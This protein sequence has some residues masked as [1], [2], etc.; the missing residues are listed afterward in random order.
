MDLNATFNASAEVSAQP[1]LWGGIECTINRVGDVFFDQLIYAQHYKRKDDIANI[2]RLGIKK[3]RYPVLWE[4]HQ[5]QLG[6]EIDWTWIAGQLEQIKDAGIDAIAGLVH[7]GSGPAFTNMLDPQF[8]YLLAAYARNV[9]ERFPH[10]KYYTPVNEPLTTARFSGLYGIWYPHHTSDE[11]FCKMLIHEVKATVLAMQAIREVNPQAQLVETEDLGK[12]YSTPLLKYQ[13]DFENERRWLTYDLL[14]GKVNKSH[15][16]YRYLLATGVSESD[17]NFFLD[18]PCVPDVFGFNHYV[19]SERFLDERLHLYAPHTHGGNGRHQYADVE[20]VRVEVEEET[21]VKVLLQ[22]AWERYHQP[23]A[24]TEVHL[25]CHREEQLRWFQYVWNAAKELKQSGVQIEAVTAWAL[26]GSYG[27]NKLLTKP[28]GTYEPG[29]FDLRG[30]YMRP[31]ALAA[32]LRKLTQTPNVAHPTLVEKGWWQRETRF[33][34]STPVLHLHIDGFAKPNTAPI[35]IVGKTG[36]LGKA[37][38]HICRERSIPFVLVGRKDCDI[39]DV[40]MVNRAIDRFKP[41]AVINT[42]GFVQVDEA[43]QQQERCFRENCTGAVVL[44]DACRQK[45]IRY[46]TFSSDM[47]FDGAKAK[48]YKESDSVNPLNVYG[49]SKARCEEEVLLA[50]HESLVV[51][52]SAFFGPWDEYN[53]LHYV[54]ENLSVQ[55]GITV[56]NDVFISPTYVPDLVHMALDLLIDEEKGIR[57]LANKG[58]ISW[59]A[60]AQE[61]AKM[62]RLNNIYINAVPLAEMKLEAKRP[63]YSVLGTEKGMI[64]PTL[65]DALRRFAQE[66]KPKVSTQLII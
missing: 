1:E 59:A 20:V 41:W 12:I 53:F 65:D 9:A 24:I 29:V 54:I 61:T 16:L 55:K 33:F 22:E 49:Q 37:F 26:L 7:H 32:Y 57:H 38:A 44:A 3:L 10:I 31:T 23:I 28:K 52:T 15:A 50:N 30:G 39:A 18:N 56:A 27:W 51:R 62:F 2:A 43:E 6:T 13:A 60:L 34:N 63:Q 14:C 35:M 4:K 36:T 47:V 66:R 42:A 19:T 64:M 58:S 46:L 8:P 5:P 21:G 17:L 25:H 40:E 48:P 11:S 45:G